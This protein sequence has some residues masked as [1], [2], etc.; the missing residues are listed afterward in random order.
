METPLITY[1]LKERG[2]KYRGTDR[3]YNIPQLVKYINGNECQEKVKNRDLVGFYGHWARRRFGMNPNEG[4]LHEDGKPF[5]IE[6]AIVTTYLKASDNGNIEHKA[7]FLKTDSGAVAEKL[8]S[9]RTGGFSSAIEG[10]RDGWFFYGFDYVLEPN[11]TNNRGYMLDDCDVDLNDPEQLEKLIYNEQLRGV[12]Y[13]LDNAEKQAGI[14]NNVRENLRTENGDLLCK[15]A[16]AERELNVFKRK[17]KSVS[18]VFYDDSNKTDGGAMNVLLVAND[19]KHKFLDSIKVFNETKNLPTFESPPQEN[20]HEYNN[21]LYR[22]L[23]K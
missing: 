6:P 3:D 7:E 13:L 16:N 19:R 15:L 18:S 12:L 2:R 14:T 4:G 17:H 20:D 5:Y 21:L 1:N 11:Y 22:F 8:F 9:S 23:H 10:S